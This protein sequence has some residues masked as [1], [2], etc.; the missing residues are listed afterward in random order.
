MDILSSLAASSSAMP[1]HHHETTAKQDGNLTITTTTTSPIMNE[2][3]VNSGTLPQPLP[4]VAATDIINNDNSNYPSSISISASQT[5]ANSP[6]QLQVQSQPLLITTSTSSTFTPLPLSLTSAGITSKALLSNLTKRSTGA[7]LYT[8]PEPGCGKQY[9]TRQG[10]VAHSKLGI[11]N[12]AQGF[13]C[14]YCGK[15]YT[16][17]K[18]LDNHERKVHADG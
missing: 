7:T 10:L 15:E 18:F 11:H 3:T 2:D 16:S 4:A 17:H 13:Q 8:C 9:T 12:F 6:D 1:V 14:K 5:A